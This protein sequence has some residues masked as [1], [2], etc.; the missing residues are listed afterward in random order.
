MIANDP[1]GDRLAVAVPDPQA[2]GGWR[3]LTGDQLGALLGAYIL[4][5]TS[6]GPDP[7]HRLVATTVVSS[8]LLSSIAAAAGAS[9]AV[10]LTGFKWIVRA[11]ERRSG[12]RFIFGY[13]E[14]LGFSIGD[15]VRDKD[16]IGAALA[17]LSLAARARSGGESLL[18]AYGALEIAHGVHLTGQ[19]TLRTG[20]PAQIMA[21][22]RSAPPA[23]F[24]GSAV[25]SVADLAGG[26]PELPSSDVLSYRLAGARVVIRPSGTEPKIKAYLEVVE[27]VSSGRLAEARH[28]AQARMDPL[29]EAVQAILAG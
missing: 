2:A 5:R 13:E 7:G 26:T 22:L 18:D 14:A 16:G 15:T 11:A 12:L 3:A 27:P 20:S 4:E 23:A 21:R 6:S 25:T 17:T 10:T 29:R 24:G 8:T 1:D 28:A 9:Y 19:L